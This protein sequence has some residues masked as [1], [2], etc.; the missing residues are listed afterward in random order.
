MWL[1]YLKQLCD[2]AF[3]DL[4]VEERT[5]LI[6]KY[7]LFLERLSC[8]FYVNSEDKTVDMEFDIKQQ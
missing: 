5:F 3:V 6:A 2:Q 8:S 1:Q 7:P 4:G